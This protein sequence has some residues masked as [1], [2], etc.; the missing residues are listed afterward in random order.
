MEQMNR[1]KR[2]YSLL[3]MR[4]FVAAIFLYHGLP[5][6]LEP[7][8]AISQFVDFGFPAFLAPV[9][10]VSEV[11]FGVMLLVGLWTR[12]SATVLSV[13]IF[14]AAVGVQFPMALREGVLA[15]SALERDLMIL[16]ATLVLSFFGPGCLAIRSIRI[17]YLD[18]PEQNLAPGGDSPP[19]PD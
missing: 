9:V 1:W 11:I 17:P 14:V 3:M 6:L 15:H 16:S 12:Y 7:A 13:I 2:Q 18:W 5:K 19:A 4:L 8:Q 10:G